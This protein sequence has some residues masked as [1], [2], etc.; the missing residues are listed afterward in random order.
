MV[1]LFLLALSV[2][3]SFESGALSGHQWIA[4]DHLVVKVPG[5]ADNAGRNHQPSWFYFSVSGVKGKALTVDIA[6]L[7]GEYD[8]RPHDGSGHRTMHPAYSYDNV[9]WQHFDR[10]EWLTNPSRI[11]VRFTAAQN[12]VWIARIPPYT[13]AHLEALLA[14]IQAHPQLAVREIGRSVQNRPL[15]LLTITDPSIP[16]GSKKTIWIIARSHA[17]E[18]G[19]SWA[20][21]G[22]VRFLLSVD[23]AAQS[24]RARY[25]FQIVPALDPD[26]VSL[27]GVRFNRNGYDLNRNW[28]LSDPA[29]MPEI[30]AAKRAMEDWLVH[31][32]KIDFFLTLHNTE[33]AD[34]L[35]GPLTAGGAATRALG[36]RLHALLQTST[37]FNDPKGP[38]DFPAEPPTPS[39]M[40]ADRWVF[41]RTGAP[42]FLMELMVDP[43][44]K[45][46]RPPV[47]QDRLSFGAALVRLIDEAIVDESPNPRAASTP[48]RERNADYSSA[49]ESYLRDDIVDGY[50]TR[51][52]RRWNRD[53]SSTAAFLKSVEPNRARYRAMLAPPDLRPSA[54]LLRKPFTAVPGLRAEWI[55]L[56]LTGGITA[57]AL[58]A[59]PANATGKVPLIVAQHGIGSFPEKLFGLEDPG[60]AYKAYGKALVDRGF[61]VLAPM[62]LFSIERRNYVE[63]L[64]RLDGT[65]LAGIEFK[66]MTLLL[67]AVLADPS[68]DSDRVGFWGISLGGMAGMYWTPLEPR[69]KASIITAWYNHRRNKMAVPDARYSSFLDTTE[70][71]VFLRGWLAEFTDSDVASLICP[72]PFMVQHGKRDRIAH[73]PQVEEEFDAARKHYEKLGLGGRAQLVMFD[74]GHEIELS[75]GLDFLSRWLAPGALK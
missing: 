46:G 64:A 68:I 7:E 75:S 62:N 19:T 73:W 22:A 25:V 74:G 31:G 48:M 72:R 49:L 18:A 15:R 3:S 56:P 24:L 26:G 69:I 35:Q 13:P 36:E 14:S 29:K 50:G 28:D 11:R 20:L 5:Q 54:P 38:R 12:T 16:P 44:P 34:Y 45:L 47:T 17:W 37:H 42:A 10:S 65:S 2:N 70:E 23:P 6:G 55:T 41:T 30:H 53:Y 71:Y 32:H 58:L 39:R 59:M 60:G 9:H 57:Q 4:P 51:A 33:S 52:A 40:T 61:A 21:E 43:N 67:D 1:A 8:F 63:R 27:G 66:R